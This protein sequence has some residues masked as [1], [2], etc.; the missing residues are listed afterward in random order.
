MRSWL[1]ALAACAAH[2]APPVR[3]PAH[4]LATAKQTAPL[5]ELVAKYPTARESVDGHLFIAALQSDHG[6]FAEAITTL[7]EILARKSLTYADRIE[8]F[9]R[10]GYALIELKRYADADAALEAAV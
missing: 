6:Q 1:I 8:A 10:K 5:R 7:D 2:P 4:D 9:A 3:A